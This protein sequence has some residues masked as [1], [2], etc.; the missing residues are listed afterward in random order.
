MALG[1]AKSDV[2]RLVVGQGMRPLLIGIGLGLA[3]ALVLTRVLTT[4]LF[5][6][7]PLIP[8]RLC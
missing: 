2:L 6:V 7:E 8:R 1:A 4:M 5:G 3:A